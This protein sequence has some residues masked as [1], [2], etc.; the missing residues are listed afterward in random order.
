MFIDEILYCKANGAYTEFYLLGNNVPVVACYLLKEVEK[1]LV[2]APFFRVNRS[3]MVNLDYCYE[4][5]TETNEIVLSNGEKL[6]VS[7]AKMKL[8]K[9]TFCTLQ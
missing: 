1:M 9:S 8:F 2:D 7:R 4:I 3:C 6:S 5:S